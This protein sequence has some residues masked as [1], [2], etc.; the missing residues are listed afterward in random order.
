MA[1]CEAYAKELHLS[2]ATTSSD[3]S[4]MATTHSSEG[5]AELDAESSSSA[6]T[7]GAPSS[8]AA[9]PS[10]VV[11]F[12]QALVHVAR[13]SRVLSME[14]VGPAHALPIV[15]PRIV[16]L[17]VPPWSVLPH[18]RQEWKQGL[19]SPFCVSIHQ[20]QDCKL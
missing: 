18:I 15:P 17:L 9:A 12:K 11:V 16:L 1:I 3:T 10:L 20:Q 8:P 14:Q 6:P 19:Q 2:A 7:S 5:G 13:I 4:S